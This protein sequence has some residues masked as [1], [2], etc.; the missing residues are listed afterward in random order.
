M[1][2][3][4]VSRNDAERER[5]Q[6][7]A[8]RLT[9]DDL[10]RRL[11]S[12]LTVAGAFVHLAFWDE[13]GRALLEHWQQPGFEPPRTDFDAVNAG[14]LRI[15]PAIPAHAAV[16][17]AVDAADAADRAVEELP[18]GVAAAI[19]DAGYGRLL[20]RSVHRSAHLDQIDAA[21]VPS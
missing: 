5:L 13:Y 20:D 15:A 2:P 8:A 21:V 6:A 10:G 14:I 16:Q 1:K 3:D 19:Q 17:M 4:Y 12:G 18:S 9:D 11:D 7:L